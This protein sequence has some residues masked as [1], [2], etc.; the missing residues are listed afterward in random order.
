[1]QS[2]TEASTR[3]DLKER[4]PHTSEPTWD[5]DLAVPF[6]VDGTGNIHTFVIN[7]AFCSE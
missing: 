3:S 6:V 5:D 4:E 2:D 1:M 7:Q